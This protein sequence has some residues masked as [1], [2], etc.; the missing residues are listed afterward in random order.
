VS[1]RAFRI[2]Y[3]EDCQVLARVRLRG[4]RNDSALSVSVADAP[5]VPS[6]ALHKD[7]SPHCALLGPPP[8]SINLAMPP[9]VCV[10]AIEW[11]SCEVTDGSHDLIRTASETTRDQCM[12]QLPNVQS[13][14]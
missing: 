6:R 13:P 8:Q 5:I 1:W 10:T 7:L 12:R 4:L 2:L 9:A 11:P 14:M 3:R